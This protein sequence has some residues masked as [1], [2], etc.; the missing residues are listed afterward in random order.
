LFYLFI[1]IL[2]VVLLGDSC[3][4]TTPFVGQG[5]NQAMLDAYSLAGI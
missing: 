1:D 2:K 3:H 5:A 4:A